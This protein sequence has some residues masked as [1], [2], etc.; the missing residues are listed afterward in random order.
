MRIE[1]EIPVRVRVI[2]VPDEAQLQELAA[3]VRVR[4][5]ARL[6][7]A[8]EVLRRR[9]GVR[10]GGACEVREAYEETRDDGAGYALPSYGHH[11]RDVGIP[12][13][14]GAGAGHGLTASRPWT[15]LRSVQFQTLVGRYLVYVAVVAGDK[16]IADAVLYS[17]IELENRWVGVWW[18]Q[19]NRDYELEKL[20]QELT[21]RA[22]ELS[23]VGDH[24]VLVWAAT[25][26]DRHRER[27][28]SI[29]EQGVVR[30]AIPSLHG[31]NAHRLRATPAPDDATP[32]PDN[33]A[34][35]QGITVSHGGWVLYTFMALPKIKLT[36]VLTLGPTLRRDLP[37]RDAEFLVDADAF[38]AATAITWQRYAEEFP[39]D[40]VPLWA[41]AATVRRRVPRAA[42]TLL[43]DRAAAHADTGGRAGVPGLQAAPSLFLLTSAQLA[44]F[45]AE[46]RGTLDSWSDDATRRIDAPPQDHLETGQRIAY[47]LGWIRL[48]PDRI[49]QAAYG[50]MA[51]TLARRIAGLLEDDPRELSWH[52]AMGNV[53]WEASTPLTQRPPG[54][55]LFEYVLA[56]LERQGRLA[57]FFTAVDASADWYLRYRL[58][59][60]CLATRYADHPLAARLRQDLSARALTGGP[61]TMVEGGEGVGE[62]WLNHNPSRKVRAGQVFGDLNDVYITTKDV[63]QLKPAKAKALRDAI[64]AEERAMAHDLFAGLLHGEYDGEGFARQALSQALPKVGLTKDDFEKVTIERSMRLRRVV[65]TTAGQLPQYRVEIEFVERVEGS[66]QWLATGGSVEES[67]GEF[68][69]RLVYWELGRAG[70]FWT[71][72]AIAISVVGLAVVAWE[73]GLVAI[74]VEA[75]GGTT[76]VLVSIGI[77]ELLYLYQVI[78]HDAKLTLRGVLEAA[79][80]GYLMALSFRWAGGLGRWGA[81]AIGTRTANRVVAGWFTERIIVGAFGGGTSAVLEKFAHESI[82]AALGEGSLSGIGDYLKTL[83]LGAATGIVMEFTVAPVMHAALSRAGSAIGSAAE[84]AA[85]VRRE[86]W[87]ALEW[88]AAVTEGLSN[89][90]AALAGAVEDALAEGWA[91]TLGERLAAVS[92]E[93]GANTLSRRVLELSGARFTRAGTAGLSRYLA[94]TGSMS[95]DRAVAA[96]NALVR[97]P[98]EAVHFFEVLSTLDAAAARHLAAGTFASQAELAEFLGRLSPYSA[99]EQRGVLR[100]LGELGIEARAPAASGADVLQR[101]FAAGLRIQAEA[102]EAQAQ[103]LQGQAAQRLERAASAAGNP[104]RAARITAEADRLARDAAVLRERARLLREEAGAPSRQPQLPPVAPLP[105][106]AVRRILYVD[107]NVID[108]VVRGNDEVARRLLALRAAGVDLRIS[109]WSWREL[110][111][112]PARA[113]TRV[114]QRLIIEDLGIA[115]DDAL[116]MARRVDEV[117]AATPPGGRTGFSPEDTQVAIGARAGQGELWSF[118]NAFRGNP[119]NAQARFGLQVAPESTLPLVR[120]PQDY[121]RAR[122][123]LGLD[124]IEIQADG[125]V[126]RGRERLA[127]PSAEEV[128]AALGGIEAGTPPPGAGAVYIRLSARAAARDAAAVAATVRPVFRS[129]TGNRVVFRV[130]GGTDAATR[131]HESLRVDASGNVAVLRTGRALNLN[132]GVF[133]RAAEFLIA[134]RRGARLVVFEVE[135]GWFQ[136]LRSTATP[137]RGQP[138]VPGGPAIRDVGG[139]PRTVDV[140]FG[141]DQLQIPD[142]AQAEL[143]EFI[144]PGSGRVVEFTP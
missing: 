85:L 47:V 24:R 105:P 61:H 98:A 123:L 140:R 14:G 52:V 75:A 127:L 126:V 91:R 49:G 95:A 12:V 81:R 124:P 18:V 86:G 114:H 106:G 28:V 33:H 7:E 133:E 129:R 87:G 55:T 144:V 92:R 102:L 108:Q 41:Q 84:M 128:D 64:A 53:F 79:L 66:A 56:E 62:I 119:A 116:P 25:P 58:M 23:R 29:D 8:D 4:V 70:E 131:S 10:R 89:F 122:R 77:S 27:L 118:D 125:S 90:R 11:G 110:A 115:V 78:F 113:E 142:S 22:G 143:Q 65:R 107:H 104:A 67:A 63:K 111:L 2:G 93:L 69:E 17:D 96:A 99:A 72:A 51:R 74:L 16:W 34:A 54:G 44:R 45:P 42:A 80:D 13:R 3:R 76:A 9:H 121:A 1:V 15:V 88:S 21:V 135:E 97:N 43:L 120:G 40:P 39:G 46:V 30:A 94:A 109:H 139:V 103:Q 73:A 68:A 59:L 112:N 19:V 132:F 101:Q 137:E 134:H 130:E 57:A 32:V 60:L 83:G 82:G 138:A 31:R 136:S 20:G 26:F 5:A 100:L 35:D 6:A 117:L 50:P 38:R 71:A 141:Q 36:D 48:D 37:L